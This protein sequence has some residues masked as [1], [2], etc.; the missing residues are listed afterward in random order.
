MVDILTEITIA[1][2]IA[3]VAQYTMDPDKAPEWYVNIQSAEWRTPKPLAPGSQIA[4]KAKFLGR[5]LAYI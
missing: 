2:P 1:K 4:F 3:I 5:E